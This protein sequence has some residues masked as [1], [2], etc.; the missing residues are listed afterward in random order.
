MRVAYSA[1][2]MCK[3]P[4]AV[5]LGNF[6][7]L[8]VGHM[9]LINTLI[10]RS[11]AQELKSMVF[12]FTK[13]PENI[14]RKNLLTPLLTT[15]EKKI[16]LLGKTP[17]DFLFFEEFDE[18]YS[19][20][21]PEVFV[22]DILLGKMKMK[23]AVAGFNYR[24]GYRG[25]GDVGLLEKLGIRYGFGL[26]VIEPVMIDDKTVSSTL[27]RELV[28]KGDVNL[29]AKYLGRFY[30]LA[31]RVRSGDRRGG[32]LGFPTANLYTDDYLV[33]PKNGVYL[34]KAF[35]DGKMHNSITNIGT[36]P[37]F[38]ESGQTSIETH[39]PGF[40]EDIYGKSIEVFFMQRIRDEIKFSS[41]GRLKERV[42]KDIETAVQ[43]HESYSKD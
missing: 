17:L 11:R 31:G 40:E 24:F 9:T 20:M 41:T 19:R 4:K 2:N 30:S 7:G 36:N 5:G 32:N 12:T 23:L 25:T 34:T 33:L 37:T 3:E 15:T 28:Q 22:E 16:E 6:D 18:K 38:N 29:A 10:E 14:L 43:L 42:K 27:I 13:H 26:I 1:Y 21:P 39:I 8:H 35:T